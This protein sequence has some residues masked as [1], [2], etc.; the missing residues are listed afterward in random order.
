MRRNL[1]GTGRPRR[2]RAGSLKNPPNV[3]APFPPVRQQHRRTGGSYS[4]RCGLEQ[5]VLATGGSAF[6]VLSK[7]LGN[8]ITAKAG[9]LL[10]IAAASGQ[11]SRC[12]SRNKIPACAV[13]TSFGQTLQTLPKTFRLLLR[14]KKRLPPSPEKTG[15]L[16]AGIR[17]S[18]CLN[19]WAAPAGRGLNEK[20]LCHTEAARER[21]YRVWAKFSNR[22][23]KAA[24][25]VFRLP[26]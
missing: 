15:S 10:G 11:T 9:I 6:S 20:P 5:G 14:L 23:K 12:F 24:R 4:C 18:G 26:F 2:N 19:I 13:M 7:F 21:R 16:K 1:F 3:N 8:V 17:F 25:K 22:T